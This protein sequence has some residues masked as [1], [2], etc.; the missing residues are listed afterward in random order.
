[1]TSHKKV[2]DGLKAAFLAAAEGIEDKRKAKLA[3]Y[4]SGLL[5]SVLPLL[6]NDDLK[7]GELLLVLLGTSALVHDIYNRKQKEPGNA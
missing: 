3:E 4:S 1:M 6:E 7:A 5:D 2:A